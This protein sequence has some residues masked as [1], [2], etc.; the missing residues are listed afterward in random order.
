VLVTHE[1]KTVEEYCH[2]AMLIEGGKIGQIGDPAEIGRHYMRLNFQPKTAPGPQ[3]DGE[4]VAAVGEGASLHDAWIEDADGRRP[5]GFEHGERIRLGAE[6]E[7]TCDTLGLSAF[8]IVA[9]ADGVNMFEFSAPIE[10]ADRSGRVRAGDR[11]RVGASLENPLAPGRY[12]AHFGV[13]QDQGKG[14]VDL[15][16]EGA[17]DFVV[18]GGERSGGV[19]ALE[20]EIEARVEPG[21]DA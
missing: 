5:N 11:A 4:A 3:G 10:G 14:D 16:V 9:N 1:M 7:L 8:F 20:H 21:G 17:I 2:R 18:F 13:R 12:F 15:F 6:V 19:L